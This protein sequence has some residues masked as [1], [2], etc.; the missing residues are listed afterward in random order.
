MS[1]ESE[2][3]AFLNDAMAAKPRKP[4][5][6]KAKPNPNVAVKY[7]RSGQRL[8]GE[9]HGWAVPVPKPT[10]YHDNK[11]IV[12]GKFVP[13]KPVTYKEETGHKS[14]VILTADDISAFKDICHAMEKLEMSNTEAAKLI[15]FTLKN[16]LRVDGDELAILGNKNDEDQE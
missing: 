6:P 15:K 11:V 4:G 9:R 14:A 10:I 5:K 1:L 13:I 2:M 7:T 16:A 12:E 3:E 8:P